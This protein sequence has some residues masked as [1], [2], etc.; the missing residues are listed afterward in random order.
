MDI[1]LIAIISFILIS[2]V[3]LLIFLY[4]NINKKS[5]TADDGSVFDDES[6]LAL[7]Q[8]LY[9]KTKPVFSSVADKAS[10]QLILGF[11]K[12]FL[13]KLTSDGFQDLKTLVKYRIQ[14]KSLSDLINN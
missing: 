1:T 9:E 5:F 13:K 12:S 8:K 11:E 14:I 2:I 4:K 10:S 7:Y 6:D 3:F